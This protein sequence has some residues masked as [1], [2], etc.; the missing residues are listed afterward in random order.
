MWFD[1]FEGN[2]WYSINSSSWMAMVHISSSRSYRFMAIIQPCPSYTFYDIL[3]LQVGTLNHLVQWLQFKC[4]LQSSIHQWCSESSIK[5][6]YGVGGA[7]D[8]NW[9]SLSI[10]YSPFTLFEF[11]F[12]VLFHSL[13]SY[14]VIVALQISILLSNA[15]QLTKTPFHIF[16]LSLC[17]LLRLL[18]FVSLLLA[19]FYGSS[20]Y[21]VSLSCHL[22]LHYFPLC[23]MLDYGSPPS[24]TSSISLAQLFIINCYALHSHHAFSIDYI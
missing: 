9:L 22:I 2:F 6:P 16:I 23:F 4:G 18:S 8:L 24:F 19:P 7:G 5:A 14:F 21:F 3:S 11:D 15:P 12:K 20:I 1:G 10:N 17:H 13:Y